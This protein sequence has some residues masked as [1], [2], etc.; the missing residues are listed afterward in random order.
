MSLQGLDVSG[1][2][3]SASDPP[4]TAAN[5]LDD[6]PRYAAQALTLHRSHRVR[7]F[8]DDLLLLLRSGDPFDYPYVDNGIDLSFRSRPRTLLSRTASVVSILTRR[9]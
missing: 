1:R 3:A 7:H 4:V 5:L 9:V 6:H 2:E 8:C